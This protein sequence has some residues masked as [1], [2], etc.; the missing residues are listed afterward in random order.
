MLC[1]SVALAREGF[2]FLFCAGVRVFVEVVW[3]FFCV[4]TG[5]MS[6]QTGASICD[7]RKKLSAFFQVSIK[8]GLKC[9]RTMQ[10]PKEVY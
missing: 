5:A 6:V 3:N 4:R 7:A 2:G 9:V 8:T 1:R 10:T